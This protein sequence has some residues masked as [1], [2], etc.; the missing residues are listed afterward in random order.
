MPK[1]AVVSHEK[2]L[3]ARK[4]FLAKEKQ[5]TR[6]RDE[7]SAQRRKLPW[8]RVEKAYVFD[9][10][11][12]KRSLAELFA[13]K[14]QLIVYHFMF[15]PKWKEGCKICSFWADN[16]ERNVVHLAA[17]DTTL[18]A[19]SRAPRPRLAAYQKRMGWTF[20]WY[21]AHGTDFNYD[22]Q[23]SSTPAE[24]ERGRGVY[25]YVQDDAMG[26]TPGVS[27]FVQD[28]RGS[29]FHTYSCYARG[30]DMLN[31]GYHY[32]DLTPKGRDEAGLPWPMDWV[33]RRDSYRA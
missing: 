25:N 18:V 12:G 16:F 32:L 5:F 24:L 28:Q 17:R 26:E 20:P 23:A 10:P 33:R 13:G 22:Y 1:P 2:W 14:S 8:E 21:S 30:L 3:K 4:A 6:L 19:I 31:A 11:K 9:G 27:V 15:A 7:L 29:V